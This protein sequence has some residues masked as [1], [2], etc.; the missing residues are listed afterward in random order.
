MRVCL[1][2]LSG[3]TSQEDAE[4]E[5]GALY[6]T[7]QVLS[8]SPLAVKSPPKLESCLISHTQNCDMAHLTGG[9]LHNL[10]ALRTSVSTARS[11]PQSEFY[12]NPHQM[13][14][15]NWNG[16]RRPPTICGKVRDVT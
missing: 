4:F 2:I 8:T 6:M 5:H 1:R 11:L 13:R 12:P 16:R 7:I 3:L 15:Q 10:H 9:V 14:R